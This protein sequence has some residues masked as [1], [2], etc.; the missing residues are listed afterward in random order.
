[1]RSTRTPALAKALAL[2]LLAA[3][4]ACTEPAVDG[5]MAPAPVQRPPPPP[6]TGRLQVE[7]LPPGATRADTVEE[8]L[9]TAFISGGRGAY[10]VAIDFF[11]PGGQA[12]QRETLAVQA[13]PDGEE[14]AVSARLPV[15]G[16]AADLSRLDGSWMARLSGPDGLAVETRFLIEGGQAP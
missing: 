2:S 4:G 14:R 3:L 10:S 7:L 12:Y 5:S 9:A 15:A 16:T 13:S 11:E 8:I 6:V 1:M